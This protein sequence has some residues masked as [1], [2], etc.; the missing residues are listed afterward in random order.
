MEES[1]RELISGVLQEDK[2]LMQLLKKRKY[3]SV[4]AYLNG[5]GFDCSMDELQEIAGELTGVK[6]NRDHSA[7]ENV[8]TVKTLSRSGKKTGKIHPTLKKAL[9]TAAIVV[10]IAVLIAAVPIGL[11]ISDDSEDTQPSRNETSE[12]MHV[13]E[14]NRPGGNLMSAR[15]GN[16]TQNDHTSSETPVSEDASEQEPVS[17]EPTNHSAEP[18]SGD[19]SS[20]SQERILENHS[21]DSS[22]TNDPQE[23]STAHEYSE[24]GLDNQ[25]PDELSDDVS[26]S[27]TG[28]TDTSENSN[29]DQ[30]STGIGLMMTASNQYKVSLSAEGGKLEETEITV[31]A[32]DP[33]GE[34]P[35][36]KNGPGHFAGWFCHPED[37]TNVAWWY[38]YSDRVTAN[39]VVS[40]QEPHTLYAH[41]TDRECSPSFIASGIDSIGS[42]DKSWSGQGP[43]TVRM[44]SDVILRGWALYEDGFDH[45]E[46]RIGGNT[47]RCDPNLCDRPEKDGMY[48]TLSLENGKDA[49][50]GSEKIPVVLEIIRNLKGGSYKLELFAVSKNGNR[51]RIL[52]GD[53]EE[54]EIIIDDGAYLAWAYASEYKGHRYKVFNEQISWSEAKAKCESLGGHL[55][56]VTSKEE[57]EFLVRL[58]GQSISCWIGLYADENG[59]WNW[60]TGEEM[61]F[62]QWDPGEPNGFP[63]ERYGAIWPI[64]WNDLCDDSFEQEGY[65]CEWDT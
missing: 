52:F 34:L 18:S 2:E 17:E 40:K 44:K 32:G 50:F 39:T 57:Q 37:M 42:G 35:V 65:I 61:S 10:L 48:G 58:K 28:N 12:K 33:Y 63:E 23:I 60:V 14:G 1:R 22:D 54:L 56:T 45:L 47:Y 64:N 24:D 3:L 59:E 4:L 29:G 6:P 36:P 9:L 19:S 46:Y 25:Q 53:A 15:P 30:P 38:A 55:V 31:T 13:I 49:G 20:D 5:H 43:L 26:E 21:G 7:S 8:K 16:K 27:G 62:T 11:S 41:W 51:D